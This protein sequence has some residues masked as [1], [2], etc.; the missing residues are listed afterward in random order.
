MPLYVVTGTLWVPCTSAEKVYL[1]ESSAQSRRTELTR[2][3]AGTST[4]CVGSAEIHP[5]PYAA[6]LRGALISTIMYG[7]IVVITYIMWRHIRVVIRYY[8][9]IENTDL[10]ISISGGL[11]VNSLEPCMTLRTSFG[12][13]CGVG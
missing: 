2:N 13:R 4:K 5:H 10:D 6:L 3:L 1:Q 11:K 12:G 9:F 7:P 8:S